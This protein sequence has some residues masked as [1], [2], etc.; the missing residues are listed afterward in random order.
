MDLLDVAGHAY[1][2]VSL[3]EYLQAAAGQYEELADLIHSLHYSLALS[4]EIERCIEPNGEV[5]DHASV[6]LKTLRKQLGSCENEL[7]AN[8]DRYIRSH[9]SHLTDT[10]TTIRNDRLVVL[11]KNTDKNNISGFIHGESASGQ[12]VYMEPDALLVLNNQR[13]SIISQ[14]KDEIQRI[15]FSL[16]QMVKHEAEAYQANLFTL[17]L[18]DSY[19]AKALWAKQYNATVTKIG[20]ELII[21]KARHPLI[22]STKV[23][24]NTYRIIPPCKTLLITGP[25]TGGKTVSLKTIGLFV[26][27]SYCGMAISCEEATIPLFDQ[28]F[29]DIG[30]NQSIVNSLS[31][32]SAHLQ[33]LAYICDHASE[34]SL[35]L[36]DE[37]GGGTDPVEGECLAISV[38]DY[39]RQ[40]QPMIVA[41]THYNGLKTY[42]KSH[43]DI[44]LASVQFDVEKLQPT[45][46]YIEGLTG[47]SNALDIAGKFGLRPE[48]V[49]YARELKMKGRTREDQLMED[50]EKAIIANQQQREA[51]AQQQ[52]SLAAV[53]ADLDKQV[54]YYQNQKETLLEQARSEADQYIA[55]IKMAADELL[56]QMREVQ[57]SGQLH[58]GI[59]LQHEISQLAETDEEPAAPL[60]DL[61]VGDYVSIN[62]TNQRGTIESLDK[63]KAIVNVNGMKIHTKRTDLRASKETLKKA[64]KISHRVSKPTALSYELNLIGMHI[65]E[66]LPVLDKYLDDCILMNAPYIR[67]IHGFGTG[68]LR[69]AIWS[70]LQNNRYVDEM[71]LGMGQEGG[72]GA[73]IITLKRKK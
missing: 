8:A 55:D 39:L 71:R 41:T 6:K 26:L 19:N 59:A 28:L 45:Y 70:H 32:F 23:V 31:T 40:L 10:I 3:T 57:T 30:D 9:A 38:L 11:V 66:A 60:T 34:N 33:K 65:D 47:Q 48:I 7:H 35:I 56:S 49:D 52:E 24:A 29:V 51:L 62:N 54:D 37:L 42:G 22:D 2:C 67:I 68:A 12:T 44:L 20:D 72:S 15:L 27:M 46:R 25:N 73:T 17:S 18:L 64:E 36:L 61:Q 69:K 16:S 21:E 5:A 4:R 53:Q 63:K 14:I 58:Q 13:L 43:P 1:C 50:L